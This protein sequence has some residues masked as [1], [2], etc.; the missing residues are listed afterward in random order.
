[1]REWLRVGK[2]R[3]R[4]Q[5]SPSTSADDY[6][7]SAEAASSSVRESDFQCF[8]TY[9]ATPS[10]MNSAPVCLKLSRYISFKPDTIVRFRARTACISTRKPSATRPKSSLRRRYEATFALWR[11]FLLGRQAMFGHD[12]P[13]YLRSITATRCPPAGNCPCGNS[14]SCSPTQDDQIVIF[15]SPSL[16]CVS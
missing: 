12:P 2:A 10:E 13:M 4:F 1:M 5:C 15:H 7:G 11:M 3:S 14:R 16:V 9:E 6:V 8:R